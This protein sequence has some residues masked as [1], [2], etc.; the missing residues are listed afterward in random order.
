MKPISNINPL[1]IKIYFV[2]LEC[3]SMKKREI[4]VNI[5]IRRAISEGNTNETVKILLSLSIT[6]VDN[7]YNKFNEVNMNSKRWILSLPIQIILMII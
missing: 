4:N 1:I 5:N 2:K 3:F 6:R 7:K